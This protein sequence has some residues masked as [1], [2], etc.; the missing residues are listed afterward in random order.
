M[1]GVWGKKK[2][3]GKEYYGVLRTTFLIDKDGKIVKVFKGVKTA[4]HS[5][6]VIAAFKGLLLSAE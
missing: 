2:M 5:K 6:E 1:Y 3:F 4:N